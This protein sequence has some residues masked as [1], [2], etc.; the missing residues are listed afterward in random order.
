MPRLVTFLL[1]LIL[2]AQARAQKW[3]LGV[4]AGA[5]GYQ[6]DLNQ[7]NPLQVSGIMQ[8]LFIR[9]NISGYASIKA[10]ISKA[11]IQGADSTSSYAQQRDRNLSFY[12]PFNEIAVVGEFNFMKYLPGDGY[13]SFTPFIYAGVAS[14]NYTPQATYNGQTYNLRELNTERTRVPYKNSAIA[15]PFGAGVKY[16]I[17]GKLTLAADLGYRT[18]YTDRL[19]DVS[20]M[21]APKDSFTD[22]IA[23]ALSDRSGER[24]GNYIGVA[25][26]QRGDTRK[27]DTYFYLGLSI[28]YTFLSQKCY[29]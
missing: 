8:G 26:T 5:A 2:S 24:T 7:R 22:P 14:V 13:N 20:G 3:E 10:G 21:Y 17:W 6:G 4:Q 28:S 23:R 11:N 27:H 25:G 16:N 18:A 19:D 9:Y 12:T 29:Y 1:L 15:I